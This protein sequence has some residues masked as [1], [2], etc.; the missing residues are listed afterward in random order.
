MVFLTTDDPGYESDTGPRSNPTVSNFEN[1]RPVETV[2]GQVQGGRAAR[3]MNRRGRAIARIVHSDPQWE[4]I[5]N[6][7]YIFN[8]GHDC[9]N[10]P[11]KTTTDYEKVEKEF[12]DKFPP[13]LH[14]L[15]WANQWKE[16]RRRA[17]NGYPVKRSRYQK[18]G[19]TTEKPTQPLLASKQLEGAVPRNQVQCFSSSECYS[20]N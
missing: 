13:E 2:M 17:P 5:A 9:I 20:V 11:S 8:V 15:R 12:R 10:G 14:A 4:S 1:N 16:S 3:Q 18:D 19:A 7:S 6:I